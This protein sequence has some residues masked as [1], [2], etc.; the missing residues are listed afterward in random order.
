MLIQFYNP[1]HIEYLIANTDSMTN[2]GWYLSFEEALEHLT[3]VP[4]C[5]TGSDYSIADLS[6]RFPNW[7]LTE[8]TRTTQPYEYW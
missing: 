7:Q 5:I 6:R 8:V 2:S 3:D 1:K 4:L